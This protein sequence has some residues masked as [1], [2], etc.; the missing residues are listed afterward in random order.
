M[1]IKEVEAKVGIT[2]KNIRFYEKEGLLNPSRQRENGYRTFSDEDV[3]RLQRIKL[4]RKLDV[5]LEDIARMLNGELGLSMGMAQ[6]LETLCDRQKNL[7]TSMALAKQLAARGGVLA[8]LDAEAELSKMAELEKEGVHFVNVEKNDK[9]RR[10]RGAYTGAALFIGVMVLVETLF[11]WA[12][13][14]A[15][16][17]L[18]ISILLLGQPLVFSVLTLVVLAQRLKEIEEDEIDDYSNY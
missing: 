9:R 4:L 13:M 10:T 14:A 15:P 12:I 11:I 16:M 7:D 2:Q 6:H 3:A 18:P 5:S 8:E 1:R 17:P